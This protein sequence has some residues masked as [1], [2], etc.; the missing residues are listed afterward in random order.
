MADTIADVLV[1][2]AVWTDLY[3]ETS[4]AV[5]TAV[6]V[7]NKGSNPCLLAISTAAPGTT[8]VGVPLYVG[9]IGSTATVAAG[10]NGLW[11]YCVN[12]T[13]SLNIQE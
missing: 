13:T 5:G 4:I 1:P 11:A 12:G 8:T 7:I 10:E 2:N 6:T 9:P 3:D